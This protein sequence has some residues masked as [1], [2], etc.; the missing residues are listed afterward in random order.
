MRLIASGVAA[1]IL[2]A[3]A[4]PSAVV[5]V[6]CDQ[7]ITQAGAQAYLRAH[8]DDPD[9][10][11][12][13]DNGIACEDRPGPFDRLAVRREL[14]DKN[15]DGQPDRPEPPESPEAG[16]QQGTFIVLPPDLYNRAVLTRNA[17][18]D[19]NPII[20]EAADRAI[21]AQRAQAAAG[22]AAAEGGITPPNT[23]DGGLLP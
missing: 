11:D 13:D 5:A 19:I 3:A 8:P 22:Q 14:P 4:L 23:G 10:L 21:A 6:N 18:G 7:F 2:V 1:L 12:D 15:G 17:G 20:L 16:I 9:G